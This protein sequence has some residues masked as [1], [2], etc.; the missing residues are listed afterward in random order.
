M[1]NNT[2]TK[3]FVPSEYQQAIFDYVTGWSADSHKAALVVQAVAGSG[4][5]T[6]QVELFK[7]LPPDLD[8]VYVA[9]NS[10][11]A[12]ELKCRLPDGA[13]ARTYHSLGLQAV[14]R[15]FP[16][17][18]VDNDKVKWVLKGRIP[19]RLK[20]TI[21]STK[22][23]V[24]VFK[25]NLLTDVDYRL[26]RD[27]ALEY[28]IDLYDERGGT[29][30]RDLI[31]KNAIYALEQAPLEMAW[32]DFDDMVYL[33]V[34]MDSIP[35]EQHTFL[36]IDE[37]QD[38]N[39]PQ[40]Y[41]AMMSIVDNGMILGVGDKFQ[42]VYRFRGADSHAMGRLTNALNADTLPLSLSYRC[43]KAVGD[44]VNKKFPEIDFHVLDN[45]LDGAVK[46]ISNC[47]IVD[48]AQDGDMILCRVNAD[49]VP[50]VFQFLR[51]G[52]KATIRG[53]SIGKNL[54]S[55]I[56]KM[57]ADN[58]QTFFQ[59]LQDWE[60]KKINTLV[61]AGKHHKIPEVYDKVKTIFALADGANTVQELIDRC[62]TLF[63]DERVGI[64]L[65]T[66]H[67]AKGLE[68]QNVFILRPDLLPHPAAKSDV[69]RQ[70]ERNIEYVAYTRAKENLYFVEA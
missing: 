13:N 5:T 1:W 63:S 44:L 34:I 11:I 28:D 54:V 25:A 35:I 39:L 37:V 3:K 50:T 32:V 4:K 57:K 48:I 38:T 67:K 64:T 33:P 22:R 45:A 36:A 7:L 70:Q 16:D 10:H 46:T 31:I 6:T 15:A 42:S 29:N 66:V 43:P 58:L 12:K 52:I 62:N 14:R 30:I 18:Q 27:A 40:L 9:F 69:D 61:A 20:F 26:A 60:Y 56:K 53:R 2:K 19:D 59:R 8:S 55:L 51:R 23:L 49:L 68:A 17:V 65:S 47:Q 41:L 21:H 24:S